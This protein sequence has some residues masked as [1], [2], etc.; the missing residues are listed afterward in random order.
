MPDCDDLVDDY[1]RLR[2]KRLLYA[3]KSEVLPSVVTHDL[4]DSRSDDVLSQMQF[5]D[6]INRAEDRVKV[7]YH[8]EFVTSDN[9]LWG[10]D[11]D[12]FVRGCH[13]G[14]FPSFYEPWGYT[15]MECVAH[16]VPTITSDLS[17][18]GSYVSRMV[19]DHEA[20]GIFIT[21]RRG[22]SFDAAAEQV[23]DWMLDFCRLDRRDRI[24]L[25]N[26]VEHRADEFDWSVMI[27]H[28]DQVHRRAALLTR[29]G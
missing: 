13:L 10:M 19:P 25:R 6:L 11:Y 18:F 15:P 9:P 3:R 8:P 4:V 29:D 17:G 12:Q 5:L 7:V 2:L 24:R 20:D 23:T 21:Q 1:W 16:G 14:V 28:Y 22:R 26:R 27:G